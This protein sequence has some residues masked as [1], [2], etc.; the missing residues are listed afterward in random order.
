[1][2]T[3]WLSWCLTAMVLLGWCC[4]VVPRWSTR[5]FLSSECGVEEKIDQHIKT[6]EWCREFLSSTC[7]TTGS[8]ESWIK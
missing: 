4:A 1:M 7:A 8:L 2:Y 5:I 3:A 6:C